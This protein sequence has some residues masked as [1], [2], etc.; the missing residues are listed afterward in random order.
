MQLL[1]D[2]V[3]LSFYKIKKKIFLSHN[4]SKLEVGLFLGKYIL[5]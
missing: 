2:L 4:L 5:Y 3:T 1:P